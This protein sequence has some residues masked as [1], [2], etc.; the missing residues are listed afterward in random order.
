MTTTN[1]NKSH[2]CLF[3]LEYLFTVWSWNT[4]RIYFKLH[5]KS[6]FFK[7][8]YK[9]FLKMFKS[10]F[11]KTLSVKKLHNIFSSS[12]CFIGVKMH[13]QQYFGRLSST[14]FRLYWGPASR[15]IL[16]FLCFSFPSISMPPPFHHIARL[17]SVQPEQR[18]SLVDRNIADKVFLHQ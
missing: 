16:S 4:F 1:Y 9:M 6:L 13:C 3:S 15:N 10:H 7:N 12:G 14:S 5:C 8:S 17:Y 18:S 2:V 11:F